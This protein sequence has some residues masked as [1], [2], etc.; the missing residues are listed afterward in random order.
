MPED[1]EQPQLLAMSDDQEPDGLTC[2][3]DGARYCG[4]DCMAYMSQPADVPLG[5]QQR[6]C[7]L[8]VGVERLARHAVIAVKILGDMNQRDN[9]AAQDR[10]RTEQKPPTPPR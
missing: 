3:L 8:L 9:V 2:F 4:A 10:K 1:L 5:P 7:L 6:N